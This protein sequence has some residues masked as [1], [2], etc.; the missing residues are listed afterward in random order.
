ML[1]PEA[2]P[3][4][5]RRDLLGGVEPVLERRVET[6]EMAAQQLQHA[7][8]SGQHGDALVMD[9]LDEARRIQTGF[10]VDLGGEQGWH[11]EAHELA[12]DV[13]E[14]QGVEEAERVEGALVAAV[15][16]DLALDGVE[17]GEH[18]AVGVDDAFRLRRGAGGEDDLERRAAVEAGR[19]ARSPARAG[20]VA[21]SARA[22]TSDGRSF[23]NSDG[24]PT[25]RRGEVSAMTRWAKRGSPAASSG[26]TRMPRSTQP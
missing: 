8:H 25:S 9:E 24:S 5:E 10:E 7:R 4:P 20:R 21:S 1:A 22:G 16:G 6:R 15:F 26:T 13:R 11:P 17:R 12:E 14:R 2:P 19:R 23:C 18:V 3:A